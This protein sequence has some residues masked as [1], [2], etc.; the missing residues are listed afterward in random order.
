MQRPDTGTS[1]HPVAPAS[2][3]AAPG[4]QKRNGH[5]RLVI[6]P[7]RPLADQTH[8]S[9][10]ARVGEVLADSLDYEQ[11]HD[12]LLDLA[13]PTLADMC[14]IHLLDQDGRFRRLAV[15]HSSEATAAVSRTL[16]DFY[17]DDGERDGPIH[18]LLANGDSLLWALGSQDVVDLVV[19]TRRRIRVEKLVDLTSIMIVPLIA[20]GRPLGVL[21]LATVAPRLPSTREDL[22]L[23]EDVARRAALALESARLYREA[24]AARLKAERAQGRL[25]F[26]A[27]ASAT[28]AGSLNV[29]AT[30]Q[31]VVEQAVPR[32]ADCCGVAILNDDGTIHR[33]AVAHV[34]PN[35][36]RRMKE[37]G[38]L[39]PLSDHPSHP[40]RRALKTGHPVI[41]RDI[42]EAD[43]RAYGDAAYLELVQAL[44]FHA[45]LVVPLEARGRRFGAVTLALADPARSLDDDD[46]ALGVELARRAALAIDNARLFRAV[47]D[48]RDDLQ[49]QFEL[50]D[51]IL[52]H[53]AEGIIV[54]DHTGVMTYVNPV[55]EE[56][57]RCSSSE[58]VGRNAHTA[59]HVLDRTGTPMPTSQC[60]LQRVFAGGAT[61]RLEHELF[62]RADGSTFPVSVVSSPLVRG[63]QVIGAVTVFRDISGEECQRKALRDS[64]ERLQRALRSAGMVMWERDFVT[65]RTVRSEL[66][67][68][69]YGRPISELLDDDNHLRLVHPDDRQQLAEKVQAAIDQGTGYELE[70]RSLWPDG[71]VRWLTGRARVFFDEDGRPRGI[72]GTTHDITARKVAELERN[73]LLAEREAEA[74]RLRV[75]HAR[76]E[77]S[78][79]ALLGLHEVGKLLISAA[80]PDA[81]PQRL[82]EIAIHAANLRAAVLQRVVDDG[83][84]VPWQSV[85]E[86]VAIAAAE[87]TSSA[88]AQLAP[89]AR[90]VALRHAWTEYVSAPDDSGRSLMVWSVPLIVKGDP[91]GVLVG[92]GDPRPSEKPTLAILGSIAL[93]AATAIENARLYR[94]VAQREQALHRLVR[95][96]MQTQEDERRRLAY[97]I[98]DGFAQLIYGLQQLLEAYA[99]ELPSDPEDAR[100]RIDLAIGLAQRVIQEIR[101]VLAGLRPTVLDDFGLARGLRAFVD[102]LRAEGFQVEFTETLGARRLPAD[103]EITLFRLAQEAVTNARKH[104]G[105]QAAELRLLLVNG[106]IILEVE[107][108]GQGFDEALGQRSEQPGAQ[109]GLL[110]MRERIAHV[111]GQLEITSRHGF[112][113]IV[114][115]AVEV[116]PESPP[117]DVILGGVPTDG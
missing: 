37:H 31:C 49:Q 40:I 7:A 105:V 100:H 13:V 107:D 51:A 111:G 3:D 78:L 64:E 36:E 33:A 55:T 47:S 87:R 32:L 29:F 84:I 45:L 82:L 81:M 8:L 110:S 71:T 20:H 26:L 109:L 69:L 6:A 27:E 96:L 21:G 22:R 90:R 86:A 43:R 115:A 25:A 116:S 38:S 56:L 92:V 30:L 61:A 112:G 34:D 62:I 52:R 46:V 91:L 28:L 41:L 58:L 70:Y 54:V 59:M 10:I 44:G 76:L 93:Q 73:Q 12:H 101:R 74:E 75:L 19:G 67:S 102:G 17:L 68:Q 108:R 14:S 98:H 106:Q 5:D 63:D 42:T 88:A 35:L 48:A 57:L 23:A 1:E 24:N 113:T 15:R 99:H 89:G 50:S 85:G 77:E 94:E 72:S 65:G 97:E 66:A 9:F 95:T 60:A 4:D 114:R 80:D 18:Q 39:L 79:D 104:A 16:G 53:I 103:L 83:S 2:G 117:P 11:T